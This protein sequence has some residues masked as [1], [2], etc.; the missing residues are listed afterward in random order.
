MEI[1]QYFFTLLL[2]IIGLV[3]AAFLPHLAVA[4]H[5][6]DLMLAVVVAWSILRGA[7]QG[8]IWA[9]AGG[10]VLDVLSGA[11]FGVFSAALAGASVVASSGAASFFRSHGLLP[12][13][14][15]MFASIAYYAICLG[16]LQLTGRPMLTPET[17]TRVVLPQ[18]ALNV[19]LMLIVFPAVRWLHRATA[20][21][22]IRW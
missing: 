15:I 16:L 10:L 20:I 17:I 22:E 6:L 2:I 4:G 11:P 18:F 9:L 21:R 5:R 8:L 14:A 3:Q 13:G 19:G 12:I 7:R 1:I